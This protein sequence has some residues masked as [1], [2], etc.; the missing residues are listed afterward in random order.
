MGNKSGGV[1]LFVGPDVARGRRSQLPRRES[2]V[3]ASKLSGSEGFGDQRANAS[4]VGRFGG[5][6]YSQR[7]GFSVR[8]SSDV[9]R[10]E[11]ARRLMVPVPAQ[12]DRDC[13]AK[14]VSAAT[15]LHHH[16]RVMSVCLANHS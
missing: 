9:V 11:G 7:D 4:L 14:G 16:N 8:K 2:A 1:V 12:R 6:K 5:E 10:C 15:R 3:G 13:A